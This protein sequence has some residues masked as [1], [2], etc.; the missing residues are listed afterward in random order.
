MVACQ[1]SIVREPKKQNKYFGVSSGKLN[2]FKMSSAA[3]VGEIFSAAG[4]AFSK[5]GELTMQLHPVAEPSPGSSKWT[6]GEIEMLQTAIKKF[7]E[8][9]VKISEVIKTRTVAQ[10]KLAIKKKAQEDAI[11]KVASP[12]KRPATTPE[13]ALSDTTE[14]IPVKKIKTELSESLVDIEGLDP[15]TSK[16]L[17]MN[18]SVTSNSDL[19]LLSR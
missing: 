10:I 7:G 12:P 14:D 1:L 5:L 11:K 4:A 8:D 6:E 9:L 19:D 15:N 3:K 2:K 17:D 18:E 16:T 13:A